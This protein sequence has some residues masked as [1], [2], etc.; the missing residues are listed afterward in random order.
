MKKYNRMITSSLLS[1]MLLFSI[2]CQA[3]PVSPSVDAAGDTA[4]DHVEANP[5]EMTTE[6][7]DNLPSASPSQVIYLSGSY[8]PGNYTGLNKA[9]FEFQSSQDLLVYFNSR[10]E[11]TVKENMP[12][13]S[14]QLDGTLINGSYTK[15][16]V[17][18][19][20]KDDN[21][22]MAR[23]KEGDIYT[24]TVNGQ[25]VEYI[26]R[27]GT[28]ELIR[29]YKHKSA[30]N[31]TAKETFTSEMATAKA[32]ELILSLYG[33]ET[34]D[35]YIHAQTSFDDQ[36]CRY[37]VA[38]VRLCHGYLTEDQIFVY[39]SQN[40]DLSSIVAIRKGYV[41]VYE[42]R[43]TPEMLAKAEATLRSAV[44]EGT[45]CGTMIVL[46]S[47]GK[48]YLQATALVEKER[49]YWFSTDDSSTTPPVYEDK[50]LLFVPLGE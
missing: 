42:D 31:H 40:G 33:Q 6:A 26:F 19:E 3:V 13:T 12:S 23:L 10:E 49:T 14:I 29:Y 22:Q 36:S 38:Y 47:D 15:T 44:T 18:T 32:H 24:G 25:T 20:I 48:C 16:M 43:L 35:Q 7:D 39:Y 41:D 8:S 1:L 21:P 34:V 50:I 4:S 11:Q 17:C 30:S 5:G 27:S 9:D 37:S 2:S 45:F 46:G 28:N